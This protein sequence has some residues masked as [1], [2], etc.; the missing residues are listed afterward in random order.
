MPKNKGKGGKSKRK[1]K[2]KN[3][4][5]DK[6]EL[7]VK[8]EGQEYAQ[9]V[10]IL[11]NCRVEAFCFDGQTRI[12][13]VRGKFRKKVWINRDDI[14]LV[15]LRDYQDSKCDV[16]HKFTAEEARRLKA[17]GELPAKTRIGIDPVD[18]E[19]GED[20]LVD[21]DVVSEEEEEEDENFTLDAL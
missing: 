1:G 5:G 4:E 15:G 14:I 3:D 16:I 2:N 18:V 21:F 20:D 8:E 12:A 10:K 6:R 11:G 19:D 13:H 17:K 7:M 9:V